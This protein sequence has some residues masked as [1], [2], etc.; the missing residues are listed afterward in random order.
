MPRK[1]R[2]T[3]SAELK[4]AISNL[5]DKEKDKLLFRLLPKEPALVD[6]LAYQL[7]EDAASM[8]ERRS[9]LKAGIQQ[10]LKQAASYFYSPGYLLLDLRAI[11][12]EINRHVK[13][14]KDKY[15]EIE[16]NFFMLNYSLDLLHNKL[17]TFRHQKSRT[18][19]SYII[20]R[21]QKLEKLM[22]KLHPDYQLDFTGDWE[23][24]IQHIE[25]LPNTKR[26]AH[27]LEFYY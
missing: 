23:K 21:A 14:T 20:K 26:M 2:A 27:L 10:E 24:L 1:Q 22:S 19:D 8:E 17:K 6:Q 13:T 4:S 16:L 15:G 9:D 11:S 7:L 18:L 3:L 25:Q 12:G 5:S